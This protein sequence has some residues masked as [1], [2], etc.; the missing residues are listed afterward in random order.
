MENRKYSQKVGIINSY[1][2]FYLQER[3]IVRGK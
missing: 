2:M 1:W 3:K